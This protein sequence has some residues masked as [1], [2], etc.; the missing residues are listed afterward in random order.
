MRLHV[1]GEWLWLLTQRCFF[2][3]ASWVRRK[4]IYVR[5]SL[6]SSHG[7][8]HA[9]GYP[10]KRWESRHTMLNLAF[11][12][13]DKQPEVSSSA[14]PSLDP[15]RIL[16]DYPHLS[17]LHSAWS[18]QRSPPKPTA[19]GAPPSPK[20]SILGAPLSC[21]SH[22]FHL[23]FWL[24]FPSPLKPFPSVG[25]NLACGETGQPLASLDPRALAQP[26]PHFLRCCPGIICPHSSHE[27]RSWPPLS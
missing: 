16:R 2:V 1:P 13:R 18:H 4:K 22:W 8:F 11:L 17:E 9:P 14:R 6:A 27:T 12:G 21:P 25:R 3:R 15:C 24:C 23:H 26:P 20:V 7:S 5:Q 19:P 10:Y